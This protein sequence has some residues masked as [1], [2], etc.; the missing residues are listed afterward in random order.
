[1][2]SGVLPEH[3]LSIIP[4][5]DDRWLNCVPELPCGMVLIPPVQ[6]ALTLEGAGVPYYES[7]AKRVT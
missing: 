7:D 2:K 4:G 1:M 3:D 5:V 6:Y